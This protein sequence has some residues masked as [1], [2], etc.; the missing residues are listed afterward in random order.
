L[1]AQKVIEFNLYNP[2]PIGELFK[3]VPDK[4]SWEVS[5]KYVRKGSIWVPN[6]TK[7]L[8]TNEILIP[9]NE[10]IASF[11][12]K[13]SASN[14]GIY[15]MFFA[16]KKTFYV[17]IAAKYSYKKNGK[18]IKLKSPEGILKRLRKHRLKCTGSN[19][20]SI[21]HTNT[22]DNGWRSF[23]I[24]RYQEHSEKGEYDVLEDCFI[25][26]INFHDP[27]M[28]INDDKGILETL[29]NDIN[30]RQDVLDIFGSPYSSFTPFGH[31]KP[32]KEPVEWKF[33]RLD[34]DF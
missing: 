3:V 1:G 11:F 23:A 31:S 24:Q 7:T 16:E 33:N 32:N 21:N 26:I 22:H 2:V 12:G 9:K 8:N 4:S 5:E 18:I 14:H 15:V 27:E 25:S 17:G 30:Y 34:F 29:E 10:K 6:R 13:H 19:V 20:W 28:Y